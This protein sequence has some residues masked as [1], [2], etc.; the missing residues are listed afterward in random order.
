MKGAVVSNGFLRGTK[1]SEPADMLCASA[2]SMGIRM[3]R[4]TNDELALPI[5]DAE[6]MKKALGDADFVVFWDK[7]V[8]CC[9][10]IEACG[11]RT[12]NSSEC[13]RLCDNK[14]LTHIALSKKGVPSLRTIA[15]PLSFDG[16]DNMS[17]ADRA[18]GILG[19]PMV[20]K[21][22]FGSFGMQVRLARNM[23]ALRSM[24][25][26]PPVP[27]ILQEY[28][29]CGASDIRLEVVG[30][31]VVAAV[32]R[33][34]PVG[35]FRSNCTIGGRMDIHAPDDDEVSIA[36]DACVAV[37]ADFAGVDLIMTPDGPAVCEVNSNAHMKN[38][39]DCTGLDVSRHIL[40]HI[41]RTMG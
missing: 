26:G 14:A 20:V 16:Y 5:G 21:D 9:E 3:S 10:N 38:L 40:E 37:G 41:V 27:R 34:G 11:Y 39:L 22:C 35:D 25:G 17:F 32:R 15:C 30:G 1:F 13:I 29:E 2:E 36:I 28:V 23:D 12:F 4:L 6:S 31:K 19:F 8:R 18:A 24:L 33:T 7:D